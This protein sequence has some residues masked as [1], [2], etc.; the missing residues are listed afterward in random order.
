MPIKNTTTTIGQLSSNYFNVWIAEDIT[1]DV[2]SEEPLYNISWFIKTKKGVSSFGFLE[3]ENPPL[4]HFMPIVM[5]SAIIDL[6]I[7]L[8]SSNKLSPYQKASKSLIHRAMIRAF[9]SKDKEV[10]VV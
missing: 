5:R 8:K 7:I 10:E 2:E 1:E 9:W 3:F 6:P 4:I